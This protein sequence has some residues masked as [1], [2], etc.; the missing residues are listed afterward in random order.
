MKTINPI[1]VHVGHQIK[2]RR[3]YLGV[4][5]SALADELGIT[6]QQVQKYEKGTNRIGASRLQAISDILGVSVDHFFKGT[7]ESVS[8]PENR[9]SDNSPALELFLASRQGCALNR[10]FGKISNETIRR[11]IVALVKI[12]AEGDMPANIPSI[13]TRRRHRLF[14]ETCAQETTGNAD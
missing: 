2:L 14:N 4:S 1:D 8:D 10:A 12:L 6:F 13:G 7:A 5:Q 9:A 3:K 11:R